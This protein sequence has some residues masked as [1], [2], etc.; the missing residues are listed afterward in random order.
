MLCSA[1]SREDILATV[2]KPALAR[3]IRAHPTDA[4]VHDRKISGWDVIRNTA[5]K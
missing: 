3:S 2:A 4:L 5:W 1:L